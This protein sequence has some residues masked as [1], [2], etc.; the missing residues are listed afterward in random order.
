M[1]VYS[2]LHRPDGPIG[3]FTN[4][5]AR[6]GQLNS[7]PDADISSMSVPDIVAN[8]TTMPKFSFLPFFD[9]LHILKPLLSPI[10]RPLSKKALSVMDDWVYAMT[11]NGVISQVSAAYPMV[12]LPTVV[13][14]DRVTH[15]CSSAKTAAAETTTSSAKSEARPPTNPNSWSKA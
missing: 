14:K 7:A 8:N 4:P 6:D 9:K 15:D 5:G 12:V 2:D 10:Q 11:W 3:Q 13:V 1:K